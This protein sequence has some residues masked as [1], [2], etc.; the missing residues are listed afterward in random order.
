MEA[1]LRG[2]LYG[3]PVGSAGT[4]V[5]LCLCVCVSV[6]LCVCVHAF[7]QL[8]H[9]GTKV[10]VCKREGERWDAPT[11]APMRPVH[12]VSSRC[13]AQWRQVT[14]RSETGGVLR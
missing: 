6:C 9:Q 8:L 14:H 7:Y 2:T 3:G 10:C 1:R 12:G 4:R 13:V 11:P 5:C